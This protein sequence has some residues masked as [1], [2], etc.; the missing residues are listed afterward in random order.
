MHEL[1]ILYHVVEQVTRIAA[2]NHVREI[3]TLVLQVGE[4]SPVIPRYLEK[5]YPVATEGSMLQNAKLQIE[6]LPANARCTGCGGVF[7]V[8]Q[9]AGVCPHCGSADCEVLGGREFLIKEI[10]A[11]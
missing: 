3:D 11:R 10:A 7:P 4:F 8:T 2:Q 6:V 9:H 1:G 5:C